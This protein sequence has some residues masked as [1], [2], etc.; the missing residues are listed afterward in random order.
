MAAKP[1]GRQE[2][3]GK[4]TDSRRDLGKAQATEEAIRHSGESFRLRTRAQVHEV[5]AACRLSFFCARRKGRAWR[6]KPHST[7]YTCPREARWSR[8]RA[9]CFP[10]SIP[11]ASS[12]STRPC[13]PRRDSLTS[14][15]W[16]RSCSPAP[17][18]SRASTTSSRTTTRRS[19]RA[20]C[21]TASSATTTAAASTTSSSTSSVT[22][23]TTSWSTPP[24]A[25]RTSRT[26]L[27]TPFPAPRSRTSPTTSHSSHSRVRGRETS[28]P[29]S[30]TQESSRRSTTPSGG[31]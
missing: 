21:A 15:T 12:R 1:K 6:E 17:R 18:R 31:T 14:R 29:G 10:F 27:P 3:S 20:A 11:P 16:A 23:S 13:A 22:R 8:L 7:R 4:R 26:W 2:L 9:T 28:S 19:R 25:R 5:H 30:P 24:T